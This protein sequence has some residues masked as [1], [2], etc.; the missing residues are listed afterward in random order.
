MRPRLGRDPELVDGLD[1]ELAVDQADGLRPDARAAGASRAGS[2]G[3]RRGACRGTPSGPSS[4]APASLSAIALPT[5]GMLRRLALAVRPRDLDRRP[6][7]GVRGAVVRHG[8]V[9]ELALD[10]EQVADVVEDLRE[11][12]VAQ[13]RDLAAPRLACSSAAASASASSSIELR[14]RRA[15]RSPADGTEPSPASWPRRRPSATS[16]PGSARRR[17]PSGHD[18]IG[19]SAAGLSLTASRL[20]QL[21]LTTLGV[22]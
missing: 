2:S 7:D 8:L 16:T 15:R 14:R 4:R 13:Q 18:A 6:P 19:A 5:P 22:D 11:L 20:T 21:R 9:H 12:A 1:A 10:L 17:R 3:T